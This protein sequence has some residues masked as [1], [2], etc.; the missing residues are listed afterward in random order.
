MGENGI[1][2]ILIVDDDPTIRK[3]LNLILSSEDFTVE[4]AYDGKI[5]VEMAGKKPYHLIFIDIQMPRMNGYEA[6][7]KIRE[8]EIS[9]PI[10]MQSSLNSKE[11]VSCAFDAGCNEFISKPY[12]FNEILRL[13]K[14]YTS[15]PATTF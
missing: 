12:D 13:L 8:M 7:K 15:Q 2:P 14:K 4:E 6:V 10:I 3:I 1:E 5:A 11:D 9:T